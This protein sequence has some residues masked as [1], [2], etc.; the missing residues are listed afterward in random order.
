MK[1]K[2]LTQKQIEQISFFQQ[3]ELN[4][5][6]VYNKLARV[7]KD[8]K[9]KATLEKI[10]KA[11][12]THY[13]F[14]KKFTNI[15][16]KPKR[17]IVFF[18][19][20][21]ARIFGLTFGIKLM[22]RGEERAQKK[23][24]GFIDIVPEAKRIERDEAEHEQ[25]LMA[26]IR[27]ERL[28]YVGSIVLGLNDALVELTG[29]LAGLSLALSQTKTIAGVGLI[30]GIAAALSMAAS[31]YLSSKADGRPSGEALTSSV[32]TGITYIV[33]VALLVFPYFLPLHSLA[34]LGITI[35]I[36]VLVI[37]LFNFYISV[38]KDLNFKRRFAEM[39]AISLGVALVSFGIGYL[40]K[41]VFN[42]S[43]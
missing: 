27:E 18:Y 28:E 8:K 36:A 20:T 31:E 38:A 24:H 26:M 3:N 41:I 10:A 11:E 9:N 34:C 30:T 37:F 42:V 40:V 13:E 43:G 39:T 6:Y 2:K 15:D 19:Y 5:H 22:E 1:I 32:Y 7:M 12:S 35:G 14:W 25:A 33:T 29:M 21:I 4:E 23:Y 16:L 17:G